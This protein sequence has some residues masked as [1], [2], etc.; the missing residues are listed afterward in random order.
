MRECRST[1][2]ARSAGATRNARCRSRAQPRVHAGRAR[3]GVVRRVH[4]AAALADSRQRDG[5]DQRLR[6][7]GARARAAG[8][9]MAGHGREH[10]LHV[11]GHDHRRGRRAAPRRARR[12]A[13]SGRRAGSSRGARPA[14][15]RAPAAVPADGRAMRRAAPARS[16]AARARRGSRVASRCHSA[17][18]AA[19]G[20]RHDVGEPRA[21]IAAGEQLALGERVRI[22]ELDRDQEAVELRFG[23][24]IRADLLDGILRGDHE[25]RL[26]QLARLAVDAT[27]AAP[28][29]PRA[30]RSA[31][32]A[33]RD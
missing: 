3:R 9:T 21:A 12:R 32:S 33:A 2:G 27:P 24:R 30:A 31:S 4:G 29:S 22:A 18:V 26:G 5:A 10:R 1:T 19:I 6:L 8:Q 25:E 16:R 15:P 28:P 14:S 23:Q 20:L 7:H 13:A 17:S 11:L